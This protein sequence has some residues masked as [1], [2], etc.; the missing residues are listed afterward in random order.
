MGGHDQTLSRRCAPQ[1]AMV[2][3]GGAIAA[4]VA[5]ATRLSPATAGLSPAAAAVAFV[6]QP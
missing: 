5:L 4:P 2:V 1:Q 6:R 3:S